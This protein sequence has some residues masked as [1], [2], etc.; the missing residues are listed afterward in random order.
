MELKEN[1][2]YIHTK[3]GYCYYYI[4]GEEAIIYNLYIEPQ[5]RRKGYAKQ[6]L[7]LVIYLIKTFGITAIQIECKPRDDS[8]SLE[9]LSRFYKSMRLQVI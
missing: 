4:E 5:Y 3:H 2:N 7:K 6:L 8:I 9:E 1:E